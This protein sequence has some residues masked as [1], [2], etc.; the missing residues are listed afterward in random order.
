MAGRGKK[1]E[2]HG[3]FSEKADARRKERSRSRA[4]IKMVRTRCAGSGKA[5]SRKACTRY[6]VLTE[7]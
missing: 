7:K 4:F 1:F 2:F 5:G 6:L 3:S